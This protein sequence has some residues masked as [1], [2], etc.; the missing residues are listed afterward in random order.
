[1]K[2][3]FRLYLLSLLFILATTFAS[4]HKTKH[5]S[6]DHAATECQICIVSQNLLS[7]DINIEFSELTLFHFGETAFLTNTSYKH[8]TLITKHSN[9]P[10]KLS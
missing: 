9:A 5:I 7:D 6:C 10:P 4:V 8:K 2:I 1:M 3:R